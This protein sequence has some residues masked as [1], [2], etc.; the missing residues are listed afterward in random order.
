MKLSV[1]CIRKHIILGG[2]IFRL[3]RRLTTMTLPTE[4]SF[5][6]F[7]GI[8][9][10]G[11]SGRARCEPGWNWRTVLDD[12]DLW[13]VAGGSGQLNIN[14]TDYEADARS[15]FLL[16][17]GDRVSAKQNPEHRLSVLFIHFQVTGAWWLQKS[18]LFTTLAD[19]RKFVVADAEL[20]ESCIGRLLEGNETETSSEEFAALLGWALI[21]LEKRDRELHEPA[22]RPSSARSIRQA[23]HYIREHIASPLALEEVA[24]CAGLSPRYF[25][26]LFKDTTGLSP[27]TFIAKARAERAARLLLESDMELNVI[28]DVLGYHDIYH[29][30]KQFKQFM[31]D[32]PSKYRAQQREYEAHY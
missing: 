2:H 28:A 32:P 19:V 22:A 13:Y 18:G 14:G 4:D 3:L 12:Y 17:P 5:A 11:I 1:I 8:Y 15:C 20:F 30:S 7:T 21:Y 25:S 29:F 27:R 26:R 6:A 24:E 23:I 10:S 16:R 31:G 9:R